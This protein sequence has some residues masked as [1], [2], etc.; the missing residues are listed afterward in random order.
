VRDRRRAGEHR[1]QPGGEGAAAE[2]DDLRSA[3]R[4]RYL[5]FRDANASDLLDALDFRRP[6]AFLE[7]PVLPAPGIA[8]TGCIEGDPGPIPPPGSVIAGR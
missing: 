2:R 1:H 6:P 3:Q 4:P 8:P 5:T 7:P